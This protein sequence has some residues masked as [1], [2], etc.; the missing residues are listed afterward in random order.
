MRKKR[1]LICFAVIA[2]LI[3]GCGEKPVVLLLELSDAEQIIAVEKDLAEIKS[4]QPYA[5]RIFWTGANP[6]IMSYENLKIRALTMRDYLVKC[7]TMTMLAR[8][9]DAVHGYGAVPHGAGGAV[10]T[11]TRPLP[12]YRRG[13]ILW[14][15]N[16]ST[17]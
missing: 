1:L 2:M 3:T 16:C 6:F 7:Q 12:I 17:S 10:Q 11:I 9:P 15:A 4:Y 8:F 13:G 14:S 5:R